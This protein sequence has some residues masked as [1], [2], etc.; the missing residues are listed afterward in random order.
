[1]KVPETYY[2]MTLQEVADVLGISKQGVAHIEERALRKLRR[3]RKIRVLHMLS[4]VR[5]LR[6]NEDAVVN[7]N[8]RMAARARRVLAEVR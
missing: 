8:C 4:M 1:M 5:E 2:A 6:H 3:H 7:R